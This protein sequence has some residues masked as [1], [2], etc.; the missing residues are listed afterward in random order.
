MNIPFGQVAMCEA[1]KACEETGLTSSVELAM[2]LPN[3]EART[4]LGHILDGYEK[5]EGWRQMDWPGESGFIPEALK[6]IRDLR[7]KL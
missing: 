1:L 3:K 6:A 2:R 5:D 4:A 7:D